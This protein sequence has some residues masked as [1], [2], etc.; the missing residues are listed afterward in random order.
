MN[1]PLRD[2]WAFAGSSLLGTV[3][4]GWLVARA[5]ES[6]SAGFVCGLAMQLTLWRLWL[7][8]TFEFGPRGIVQSVLGRARLVTW[9]RI[10]AVRLRPAGIL[11][12]FD[13]RELPLAVFSSLYV[14]WRDQQTAVLAV[15][16]QYVPTRTEAELASSNQPND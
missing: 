10:S 15:V 11:I 4:L 5:T 9:N 1:W 3:L 16:R 14:R 2:D 13:Q 8:V 7:P 12:T 6:A